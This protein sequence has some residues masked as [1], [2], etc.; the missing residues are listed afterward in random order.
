[1]LLFIFIKIFL[2]ISVSQE[3]FLISDPHCRCFSVLV[4]VDNKL[5]HDL[6]DDEQNKTNTM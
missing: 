1:M 3:Y 2:I 6:C 4:A 5:R